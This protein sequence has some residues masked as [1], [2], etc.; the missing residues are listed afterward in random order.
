MNQQ[1]CAAESMCTAARQ[2]PRQWSLTH[3]SP[4]TS[5]LPKNLLTGRVVVGGR[6][7]NVRATSRQRQ[8]RRE[9]KGLTWIDPGLTDHHHSEIWSLRHTLPGKIN[10]K[11]RNLKLQISILF[12]NFRWRAKCSDVWNL[13]RMR[14][15]I[16]VTQLRLMQGSDPGLPQELWAL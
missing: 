2:L 11:D 4:T 16:L 5:S 13:H 10:S 7:T 3:C 1:E 6:L 14:Q 8:S 15:G 12:T 9:V